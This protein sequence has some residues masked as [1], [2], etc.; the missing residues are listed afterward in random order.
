MILRYR[1]TEAKGK[2]PKNNQEGTWAKKKG[3]IGI[4]EW[5]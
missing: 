3:A 5:E 1:K 2:V 4:K